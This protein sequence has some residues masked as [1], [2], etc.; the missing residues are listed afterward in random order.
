M[1]SCER[2]A[3]ALKPSF[4]ITI[5]IIFKLNFFINSRFSSKY[6]L[7]FV[8]ARADAILFRVIYCTVFLQV[9]L[10]LVL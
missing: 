3:D 8:K 7:K 6:C 10:A 5:C 2:P 4:K 9:Q 1:V